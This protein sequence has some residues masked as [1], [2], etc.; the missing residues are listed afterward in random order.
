MARKE[1]QQ[2]VVIE[3]ARLIFRNFSGKQTRFNPQG[4]RTFCVLLP[5]DVGETLGKD[6]WNVKYL[7]PR[8]EGDLRQPFLDVK[9]QFGSIKPKIVTITSR[10]QTIL[11]E[12]SVSNLDWAEIDNAD[13]VIR[14]YNWEVSGKR[15]VKAYLK[16]MYV[17]LVEDEFERKY[18]DHVPLEDEWD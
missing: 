14:P 5:Q 8:E 10:G 3:N 13:L 1:I 11:D 15:G 7:E 9:V 17:T 18:A 6:G 2:N 12:D 4:V 16:T